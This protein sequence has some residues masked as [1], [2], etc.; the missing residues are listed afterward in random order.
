M[1]DVEVVILQHRVAD[2]ECPGD[3]GPYH[4]WSC[5]GPFTVSCDGCGADGVITQTT[6]PEAEDY[7][8]SYDEIEEEEDDDGD[9]D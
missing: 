2:T 6:L 8:E 4:M 1:I 5:D 9:G 7:E 3:D